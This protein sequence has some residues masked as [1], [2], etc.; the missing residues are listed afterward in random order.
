MQTRPGFLP[1]TKYNQKSQVERRKLTLRT[2]C[3]GFLYKARPKKEGSQGLELQR[4]MIFQ[5]QPLFK[6]TAKEVTAFKAQE[7]AAHCPLPLRSN[8]LVDVS[9]LQ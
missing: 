4:V 8:A 7:D 5:I 9:Y 2:E 3:L 6:N 1:R